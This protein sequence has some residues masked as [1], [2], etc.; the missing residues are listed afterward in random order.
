MLLHIRVT[1]SIKFAGTHLYTLVKKGT[2][3]ECLSQEQTQ[4]A[5]SGVGSTSYNFLMRDQRTRLLAQPREDKMRSSFQ[6]ASC[7]KKYNAKRNN[8]MSENNGPDYD[9]AE[10]GHY[11]IYLWYPMIN[12]LC[13][14]FFYLNKAK[15][16]PK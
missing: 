4:T 8:Y 2:V 1:S 3:R 15:N 13:F 9:L 12:S 11:T 7:L 14:A 16:T 10:L 5:R 6:R